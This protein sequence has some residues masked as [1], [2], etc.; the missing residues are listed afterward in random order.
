ME[1][2]LDVKLCCAID[3]AHRERANALLRIFVRKCVYQK[4]NYFIYREN[5]GCRRFKR[6]NWREKKSVGVDD[7]DV[8][9]FS[10]CHGNFDG[11]GGEYRRQGVG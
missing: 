10:P 8:D 11:L 6:Y 3:A 7:G 5:R 2:P 1:R 9:I 4:V